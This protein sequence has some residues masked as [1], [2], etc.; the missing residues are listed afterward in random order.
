MLKLGYIENPRSDDFEGVINNF[1]LQ[2]ENKSEDAS[3]NLIITSLTERYIYQRN[4]KYCLHLQN[5]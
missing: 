3:L 1:F 5:D 4:K 2:S